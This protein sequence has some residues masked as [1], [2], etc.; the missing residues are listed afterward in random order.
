VYKIKCSNCDINYVGQ[1][2][3]QLGTRLKEHMSDIKKRAVYCL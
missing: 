1:T 2:K 3:R